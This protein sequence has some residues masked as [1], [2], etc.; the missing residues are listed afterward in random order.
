M[1][2]R[3]YDTSTRSV[4]DFVPLQEG[5]VSVYYCGATV[6]ASPHVGHLRP[7][8]VFDVL[9]RW[10]MARGYDVTVC[11]NVT[12]IDDKIL[13]KAAQ[14]QRPWWAVAQHYEREFSH[15]YEILGCLPPTVEPRATGHIPQMIALIGRLLDSG[16]A[17][18]V[19]GDVY[20]SV[21][22]Y[23]D[24]G[25]LSRQ[26]PDDLQAAADPAGD[27][28]KR[29]PRDFALWKAAKPG[30]PAW[31][32]P[33]GPGR[34]GWHLECSAM[35]VYYLGEQFD[36]HGGGI[37]LIFPHHENELAQSKAAGDP[38]AR[39]WLHNSWVTAAGEKMGKSLGNALAVDEVLKHVRPVELR[40]YLAAA[41]YRS[42]L[43]FSYESV[44]ESAVGFRRIS[45]FLQRLAG[46]PLPAALASECPDPFVA[47][48]D[49]DLGVPAAVAVIFDTVR[50]GNG[51]IEAGDE[52]AARR[53]WRS[54]SAMCS[55]L[56]V[57]PLEDPWRSR[58]R[59]S[60]QAATALSALVEELLA[61][62]QQARA[63]RDWAQADAIRDRL[64]GAGVQIE[65]RPT[66]PVWAVV[67]DGR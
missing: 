18:A 4:R 17:Y 14:E 57:N 5:R 43:E 55:V 42:T 47:A 61:A 54:V 52:Q 63:D 11:R 60:E 27:V 46:E 30:E 10:M 51:A 9:R 15:A 7:G 12:D 23:P 53:A 65:D 22:S 29:D 38:F 40:Y 33:W 35:A 31:E 62:R 13:L 28:L 6:Q 16:A 25:Q 58:D 26:R 1:T 37:D 66:G 48:M 3:L 19:G 44:T 39:Y 45:A 64:A 49:D 59:E 41:H 20:F 67:S 36:I 32:S 2:L 8:V 34:P 56:G 50:V 21:A 24:Y